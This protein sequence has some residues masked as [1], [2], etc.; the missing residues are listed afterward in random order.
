MNIDVVGRIKP[1][2][3]DNNSFDVDKY[4]HKIVYQTGGN[5]FR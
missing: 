1:T 2:G 3:H 4:A 5:S